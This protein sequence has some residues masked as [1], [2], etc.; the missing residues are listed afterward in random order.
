MDPAL[1]VFRFEGNTVALYLDR[2]ADGTVSVYSATSMSTVALPTIDLDKSI[3]GCWFAAQ[4]GEGVTLIVGAADGPKARV[5]FDL[6]DVPALYAALVECR[7]RAC[8]AGKIPPLARPHEP[9]IEPKRKAP[10]RTAKPRRA[11]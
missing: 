2:G 6:D 7:S 3:A 9:T 10:A 4:R 8:T 11:A 5:D 1:C